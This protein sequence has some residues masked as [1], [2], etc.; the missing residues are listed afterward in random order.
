MVVRPRI[1]RTN[2]LVTDDRRFWKG[3]TAMTRPVG[4][5]IEPTSRCFTCNASVYYETSSHL[6]FIDKQARL[7]DMATT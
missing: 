5:D 4:N 7:L 2:D 1:A 3:N 6:R